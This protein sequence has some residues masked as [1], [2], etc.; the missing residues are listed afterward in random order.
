[1]CFVPFR[2]TKRAFFWKCVYKG[3]L[4]LCFKTIAACEID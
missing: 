3:K 2:Y 4:L 1:M